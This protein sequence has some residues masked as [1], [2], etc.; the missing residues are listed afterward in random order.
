[1][2][3]YGLL[4]RKELRNCEAAAKYGI[5]K[6]AVNSHTGTFKRKARELFPHLKDFI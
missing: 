6:Y 5:T 2:D 1:M 3:R 4:G